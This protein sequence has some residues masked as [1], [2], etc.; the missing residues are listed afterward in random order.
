[1]RSVSTLPSLLLA[2]EEE[3]EKRVSDVVSVYAEIHASFLAWPY[4][5][6]RP[7]AFHIQ[8]NKN[9]YIIKNVEKV[10]QL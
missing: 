7:S 10:L 6:F 1:M 3:E 5:Q 2:L 8:A 4:M 9:N